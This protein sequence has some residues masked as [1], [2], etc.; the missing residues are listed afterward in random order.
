[1]MK[2]ITIAYIGG[3]S[4]DWAHKYFADLLTKDK[5]CGELRLYDIDVEAANRNKKYFDKL[6]QDNASMVK[7]EWVCNVINDINEA[8][9][10]A[11]FVLIS[12]LPY[13]LT[14]MKIDVH[15]PEKYGI[16]Q[17]VGDTVGPGGYSRALRTI[18]YFK[19][20]ADRIRAN[21]PDAWVINYTN[22][23][24]MCVNTLYKEFPQI[25]A[26][27]CCHEVFGLQ[28]ILAA[29]AGMYLEMPEKGRKEFLA[30]NLNA[31]KN[32]LKSKGKNFNNMYCC[33][34]IDRHDIKINVQGINHFTWID[35]ANY[36]DLDLFP[37]YSAFI[38][39]FREN[40]KAR[41]GPLV[42][43]LIKR[44]RNVESVK[45]ELFE[46]FNR[47]AA[48]GDR[49]LAEF[50]P[51]M[52]LRD[53][54]VLKNG[55]FLT[56]VWGRIAYNNI[57]KAK[58]K[59]R[60]TPLFKAKLKVSGEEGV[61]QISALCGLGDLISNVNLP[62]KGQAA[63]LV[64]GTAVETNARF[65]DNCIEA[66]PAG[67]MTEETAKIVNVHAQNQKDFVDA[68][69]RQDKAALCDVFCN[70]P[71]VKRIGKEKGAK[72]F[73]EMIEANKKCLDSFLKISK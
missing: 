6:K 22:P 33:E 2:K 43:A 1:M 20:F 30:A 47:M 62:N 53:K 15:Y 57:L 60:N 17:S 41:L 67:F 3:G 26:F 54:H 23:L 73:E 50:V 10:G 28:E 49:H 7:S 51:D 5:V 70:D 48:A 9:T 25:K 66:I 21:C 8:L 14:N 31:V 63:N 34:K 65:T 35:K 27:G 61:A 45:F 29:I 69:F 16:W 40:N 18:S 12:I 71:A 52:Y 11:D 42:P 56:P 36:K 4:K 13:S 39:M 68:F 32:E 19:Y 55:F 24:A 59:I 72:L 46:K 58:I 64:E 37:I 44:K 38:K